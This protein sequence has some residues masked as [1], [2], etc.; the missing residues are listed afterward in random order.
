MRCVLFTLVPIVLVCLCSC[1]TTFNLKE[2][3]TELE[4]SGSYL[5]TEQPESEWYRRAFVFDTIVTPYVYTVSP[6]FELHNQW[7][8]NKFQFMGIPIHQYTWLVAPF[9]GATILFSNRDVI[10]YIRPVIGMG[11]QKTNTNGNDDSDSCFAFGAGI[12]LKIPASSDVT[13]NL[14]FGWRRFDWDKDFGEEED[15]FGVT[16]GFAIWF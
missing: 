13:F 4:F 16:V 12:G 11:Y 1:Q 10:P 3:A 8:K 6:S 5:Y 15:I 2:G 9:I 7:A 14:E